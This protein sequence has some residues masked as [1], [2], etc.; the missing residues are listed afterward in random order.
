VRRSKIR[1]CE[2]EDTEDRIEGE[3]GEK[4]AL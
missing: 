1:R 4:E 3:W 2:S